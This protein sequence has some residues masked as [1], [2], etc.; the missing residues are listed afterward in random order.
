MAN[1]SIAQTL[2]F[3]AKISALVND[4]TV[5]EREIEAMRTLESIGS[6][7]IPYMVAHLKDMRPIPVP[8]IS[9]VNHSPTAFEGLRHYSPKTVHDALS[10]ILNQITGQHFEF[11]YNGASETMRKANLEQ[12]HLW[13]I[14]TFPA[15]AS[16]CTTGA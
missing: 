16:I 10:A 8:S 5:K 9:L 6:E 1:S 11:V 13:C 2:S 4:L 12:W 15:Q 14:K 7:G 3:S